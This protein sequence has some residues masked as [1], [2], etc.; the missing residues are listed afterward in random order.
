MDV[1][2]VPRGK[3][4]AGSDFVGRSDV[5]LEPAV[6]VFN[7]DAMEHVDLIDPTSR[8]VGEAGILR[9]RHTGHCDDRRPNNPDSNSSPDRRPQPGA[10][11]PILGG[12]PAWRTR[13][14]GHPL[15]CQR[16]PLAPH[17]AG[18][19]EPLWAVAWRQPLEEN[20]G[21]AGVGSGPTG[22]ACMELHFLC[23][24]MNER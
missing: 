19:V 2:E 8:R 12:R 18:Q 20:D 5:R 23:F 10:R 24:A 7:P 6:R 4:R 17:G 14:T 15:H 9:D 22:V 13:R 1:W 21:L 16:R 3:S 11:R